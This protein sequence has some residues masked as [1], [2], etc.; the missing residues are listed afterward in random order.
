LNVY[1]YNQSARSLIS[2]DNV[3]KLRQ[4]GRKGLSAT[5]VAH[6]DLTIVAVVTVGADWIS[7]ERDGQEVT[8]SVAGTKHLLQRYFAIQVEQQIAHRVDMVYDSCEV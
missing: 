5:L 6:T 3:D 2:V 7:H 4:T 1:Y 8:T